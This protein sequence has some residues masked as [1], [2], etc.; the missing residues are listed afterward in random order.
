MMDIVIPLGSGSGW[1]NNE[2]RFAL[3]SI[4]MHIADRGKIFIIGHRPEWIKNIVH[5]PAKDQPGLVNKERNIMQKISLACKHPAISQ[6]FV[7]M[8]D[9][10]FLLQ[11]LTFPMP[12]YYHQSLNSSVVKRTSGDG[13]SQSMRNTMEVLQKGG[14]TTYNFDIHCPIVYDKTKF[15]KVMKCVDWSAA[16]GYV[17]KSLY[18]N[19]LRLPG[20]V[21]MDLKIRHRCNCFE[22]EALT[23]GRRVFSIDDGAVGGELTTFLFYLFPNKSRFE[24]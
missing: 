18:C 3:R 17:I 12:Y 6:E 24:V 14:L 10:H 8:N 16:Y 19:A 9:D 11:P 23:Y 20:T 21:D 1:D 22:L 4:E 2:L 5:I 13:Y 7:F 15:L